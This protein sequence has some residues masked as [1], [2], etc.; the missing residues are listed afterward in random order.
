M[1]NF[2]RVKSPNDTYIVE[3]IIIKNQKDSN[4]IKSVVYNLDDCIT[5]SI[6]GQEDYASLE[7]IRYLK[8]C[9]IT[10]DLKR[11]LGTRDMLNTALEFVKLKSPKKFSYF[12]LNDLSYLDRDNSERVNLFVSHLLLD[13]KTWYEK[14]FNAKFSPRINDPKVYKNYIILYNESL[15]RL[16]NPDFKD[17]IS[18]DDFEYIIGKRLGDD[19]RLIYINANNFVDFFNLVL[20][21]FNNDYKQFNH[22]IK[23]WAERFL[24]ETIFN[25]NSFLMNDYYRIDINKLEY[26][27][28][29]QI[30][31]V[32]KGGTSKMGK[33]TLFY[34]SNYLILNR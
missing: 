11:G 4:D 28:K 15:D 27:G 1:P 16:V 21:L 17:T 33:K 8:K 24:K 32:Q 5:I 29:I 7:S 34:T 6:T 3:E 25:G 14:Y 26:D 10:N 13:G 30:E 23:Q 19:I 31:E 9:N 20:K 18:I 22:F 12:K 2:F